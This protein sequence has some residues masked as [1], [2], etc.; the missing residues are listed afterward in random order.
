M[1]LDGWDRLACAQ[2]VWGD[3]T[4]LTKENAEKIVD[5]DGRDDCFFWP[6]KEGMS[7]DAAKVLQK[8]AAENR[9]LKTSHRLTQIGLGIAAAALVVT[10]WSS[11]SG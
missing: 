1:A 5:K 2:E 4:L 7:I 6:V 9:E 10:A 8:R 11:C 3:G